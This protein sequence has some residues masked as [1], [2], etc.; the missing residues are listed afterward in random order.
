[1]EKI[2]I[3]KGLCDECNTE[4][5]RLIKLLTK[6]VPGKVDSKNVDVLLYIPIKFKISD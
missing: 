4:A 2:I 1:M 5:I 3:E 6:W